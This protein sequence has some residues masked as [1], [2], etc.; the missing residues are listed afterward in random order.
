MK[1]Q[2]LDLLELEVNGSEIN[3]EGKTLESL[4]N[5]LLS[6][7]NR[8]GVVLEWQCDKIDI[9]YYLNI[10][11]FMLKIRDKLQYGKQREGFIVLSEK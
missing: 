2:A 10:N 5:F 8:W 9:I 3:W 11:Q 1:G 7:Q 4:L 6:S